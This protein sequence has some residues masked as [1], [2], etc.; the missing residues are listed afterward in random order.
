MRSRFDGFLLTV[1]QMALTGLIGASFGAA[2]WLLWIYAAA[3][4]RLPLKAAAGPLVGVLL[5][6]LVFKGERYF[7]LAADE[8]QADIPST[9]SSAR[10]AACAC[11]V[12]GGIGLLLTG[13]FVDSILRGFL[14]QLFVPFVASLVTLFVAGAIVSL[15]LKALPTE[16]ERHDSN[17]FM[18]LLM[19]LIL[20]G[21]LGCILSGVLAGVHEAMLSEE[22]ID[23][24]HVKYGGW[25]M[26]VMG[27][28]LASYVFGARR[29]AMPC[30]MLL[31]FCL[32]L[33]VSLPWWGHIP[34]PA[35][36]AE[37]NVEPGADGQIPAPAPTVKPPE[38]PQEDPL[39]TQFNYFA[40]LPIQAIGAIMAA[41]D[42][43]AETWDRFEL[44]ALG[45]DVSPRKTP[46][47]QAGRLPGAAAK[48]TVV[49]RC[50]G[51]EDRAEWLIQNPPPAFLTWLL[52]REGARLG[53]YNRFAWQ[54]TLSAI[55]S[56]EDPISAAAESAKRANPVNADWRNRLERVLT[57]PTNSAARAALAAKVPMIF[58][59]DPIRLYQKRS[60]TSAVPG[61]AAGAGEQPQQ[62]EPAS[63]AAPAADVK[64]APEPVS[65]VLLAALAKV[66]DSPP[67]RPT[68]L[69]LISQGNT[70]L[71]A[72]VRDEIRT[73]I[74]D[75][76]S[77]AILNTLKENPDDAQLLR[78]SKAAY[79]K[80]LE[81]RYAQSESI[82]DAYEW[83]TSRLC[84]E[85]RKGLSSGLL[86]S[87]LVLLAFS[88]GVA[89]A[90]SIERQLRP[91]DYP[92]S[93]TRRSD[94]R[95]ALGSIVFVVLGIL[96]VRYVDALGELFDSA[97]QFEIVGRLVGL[98]VVALAAMAIRRG[99]PRIRQ[100]MRWMFQA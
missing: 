92:T 43:P 40:S 5:G 61:G 3:L 56:A 79:D 31:S 80:A 9:A 7:R 50:L 53:M 30:G 97:A 4:G 75:P 10:P 12:G 34:P 94:I 62:N 17:F 47:T 8:A 74:Y 100:N 16:H 73:K 86:R 42:L 93:K 83:R 39:V 70:G 95:L 13:F 21:V 54:D 84:I 64:P 35:F 76:F 18:R 38:P 41:P 22:A 24:R 60:P 28:L 59:A 96:V 32:V 37:E 46:P 20:G 45:D 58:P 49:E 48:G 78:E 26:F 98:A 57:D 63:D 1:R 27:T 51:C 19:A 89:L 2:A 69:Q 99:W 14:R 29:L 55:A 25:A 91:V 82:M 90:T 33:T 23:P 67:I 77:V 65:P 68:E 52:E 15:I 36:S 44:R 88:V 85:S 71:P 87:W 6:W 11:F 72:S 66:I 81:N